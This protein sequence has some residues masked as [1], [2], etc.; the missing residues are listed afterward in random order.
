ME[1]SIDDGLR[2]VEAIQVFHFSIVID[3]HVIRLANMVEDIVGC[4]TK[5]QPV[6]CHAWHD[7]YRKMTITQTEAARKV[8]EM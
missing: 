3:S 4:C 8:R 2:V 5:R 7:P 6:D 1:T